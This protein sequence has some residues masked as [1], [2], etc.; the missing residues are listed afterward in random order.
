MTV[1]SD[2]LR[3][4][5]F[6][7]NK[8]IERGVK[9]HYPARATHLKKDPSSGATEVEIEQLDSKLTSN[10]PCANLVFAA[11]VWTPRVFAS[12]FPECEVPVPVLGLAGYSLVLRSPRHTSTHEGDRYGGNSH[13]VFTSN[14]FSAGFSPDIFSRPGGEIYISGLN[15]PELHPPNVATDTRQMMEKEMSAELKRAAVGLMGKPGKQTENEDD[16]EVEREGLCFRPLTKSGIPIV[17]KLPKQALGDSDVVP[18]SGVFMGV[19]HGPWGISLSLGT[20]KVLAERISGMSPSAD[21][22]TLGF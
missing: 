5:R 17:S 3:L 1:F 18:S 10:I 13:A 16:L 11:G 8:C 7:M 21:V 2:P 15:V 19:G 20:G 4:S 22:S 12:L 9:V 14:P 6:L